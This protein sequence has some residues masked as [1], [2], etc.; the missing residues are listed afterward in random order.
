[1]A[2]GVS[3]GRADKKTRYKIIEQNSIRES[4]GKLIKKFA[5]TNLV[6]AQKQSH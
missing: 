6:F 2:V 3:V 1:M 4:D 5:C